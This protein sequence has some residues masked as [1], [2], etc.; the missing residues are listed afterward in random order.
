LTAVEPRGA[1][2]D[3]LEM[4]DRI[5]AAMRGVGELEAADPQLGERLRVQLMTELAQLP[6]TEA[7][8]PSGDLVTALDCIGELATRLGRLSGHEYVHAF[9]VAVAVLFPAAGA[10]PS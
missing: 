5:V 3:L 10:P 7:R 1:V 8:D 4:F 6:S 2:P 9:R